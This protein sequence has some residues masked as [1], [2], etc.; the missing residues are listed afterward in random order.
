MLRFHVNI[1]YIMYFC[2]F[3]VQFIAPTH[4]N[5]RLSQ[6]VRKLYVVCEI[7]FENDDITYLFCVDKIR[8]AYLVLNDKYTRHNQ[9]WW[10]TKCAYC[11]TFQLKLQNTIQQ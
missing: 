7:N 9:M 8:T 3:D 4:T 11:R 5:V 6:I 2:F 1:D 10:F